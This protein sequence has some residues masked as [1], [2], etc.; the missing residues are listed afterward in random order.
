MVEDVLGKPE[1]MKVLDEDLKICLWV[2]REFGKVWD[3]NKGK[4]GDDIGCKYI[5]GI[6]I[7]LTLTLECVLYPLE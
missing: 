7:D 3:V 1:D 5:Y 6:R 4:N 2:L